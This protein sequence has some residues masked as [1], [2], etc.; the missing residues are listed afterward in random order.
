[1]LSLISQQ[2]D[3]EQDQ[4]KILNYKPSQKKKKTL[5]LH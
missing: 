1:M 2:Q 4:R 3:W 5:W